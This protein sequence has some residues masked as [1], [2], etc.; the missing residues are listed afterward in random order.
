MYVGGGV[1]GRRAGAESHPESP[2]LLT[3][4]SS[5][6]FHFLVPLFSCFTFPIPSPVKVPVLSNSSPGC[7]PPPGKLQDN[8][9]K[10]GPLSGG[11]N[12]STVCIVLS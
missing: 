12:G 10:Q 7:A 1:R 6:S 8:S 5:L 3:L 11:T 4:W 2:G 9:R